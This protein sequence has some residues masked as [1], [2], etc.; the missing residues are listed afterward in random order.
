MRFCRMDMRVRGRK[1][2]TLDF[3]LEERSTLKAEFKTLG[4]DNEGILNWRLYGG[5]SESAI[6]GK[7]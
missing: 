1:W 4:G 2:E 3:Y 5:R 6:W 7:K